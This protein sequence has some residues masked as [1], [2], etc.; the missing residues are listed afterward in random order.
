MGNLCF[1]GLM[2]WGVVAHA[3]TE[4][5]YRFVMWRDDDTAASFMG[6]VQRLKN[7]PMT[8][9]CSYELRFCGQAVELEKSTEICGSSR[10]QPVM[11]ETKTL[12]KHGE[13]RR[14]KFDLSGVRPEEELLRYRVELNFSMRG[15]LMANMSSIELVRKVP[16]EN[17]TVE[18]FGKKAA[19]FELSAKCKH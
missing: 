5:I 10:G 16:G 13:S 11:A 4:K 18:P 17:T 6:Q 14:L 1:V 15:Q 12:E 19:F 9:K 8:G 2:L 3:G 7:L